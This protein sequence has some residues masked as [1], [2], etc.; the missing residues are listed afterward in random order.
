MDDGRYQPRARL[1]VGDGCQKQ[2]V[3]AVIPASSFFFAHTCARI[4]AFH[5]HCLTSRQH[6]S[7]PRSPDLTLTEADFSSPVRT[8]YFFSAVD[9]VPSALTPQRR[10]RFRGPC[11]YFIIE[12]NPLDASSQAA[13]PRSGAFCT[14]W[15]YGNSFE[16]YLSSYRSPWRWATIPTCWDV[17]EISHP[18]LRIVPMFRFKNDSA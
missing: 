10:S 15:T 17:V 18:R 9:S 13:V 14:A 5:H 1:D 11:L 7:P 16:K 8:D 4:L 2:T 12:R 3:A 6:F